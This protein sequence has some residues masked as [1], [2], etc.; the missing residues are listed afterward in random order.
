MNGNEVLYPVYDI[1]LIY[2]CK[3][4]RFRISPQIS[5]FNCPR[6]DCMQRVEEGRAV[7]N[8]DIDSGWVV[9]ACDEYLTHFGLL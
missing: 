4:L 1:F 3:S 9:G 6:R 5:C 2:S 7:W 8:W